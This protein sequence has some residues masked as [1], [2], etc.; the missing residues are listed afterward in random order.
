MTAAKIAHLLI[1]AVIV[2]DSLS[3]Q[4]FF[5]LEH[6]NYLHYNTFQITINLIIPIT[7]LFFGSR[8]KLS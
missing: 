7:F 5:G 6:C 1:N 3:P 8:Q 2:L 4:L